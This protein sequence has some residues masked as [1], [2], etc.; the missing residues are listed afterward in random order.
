MNRNGNRI[1]ALQITHDYTSDS[2]VTIYE[3]DRL[4]L[5]SQI[6][7]SA[8]SGRSPSTDG[9]GLLF[10]PLQTAQ[11]PDNCAPPASEAL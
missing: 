6:P 5:L 1:Q 3:G 10:T 9:L 7:D 2:Q 4:E 8:A 11:L